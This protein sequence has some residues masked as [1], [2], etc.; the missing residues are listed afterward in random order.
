MDKELL[1]D[2]L[3]SLDFNEGFKIKSE[4]F[5]FGVMR[6]NL[7]DSDS[8]VFTVYGGELKSYWLENHSFEE[9]ADEIEK[10][11]NGFDYKDFQ[12][13]LILEDCVIV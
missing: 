12:R 3:E 6:V 13:G 10:Y 1:I 2:H 9:V 11:I 7:F 4:T 8:I 5:Y